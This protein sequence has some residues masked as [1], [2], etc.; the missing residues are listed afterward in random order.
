M[1]APYISCVGILLI[2]G[3]AA[4]HHARTLAV[5][6]DQDLVAY[7][8]AVD[9]KVIAEN[10]FYRDQLGTIR[11]YLGGNS[12]IAIGTNASPTNFANLTDEGR[13]Q[14][15]LPYGRIITR[16]EHDARI[17]AEKVISAEKDPPVMATIMA[18]VEGG[19]NEEQ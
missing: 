18:Y 2:C 4:D 12:P 19:L 9:A 5:H 13:I 16:A 14:K 6:V 11:K 7:E 8:N 17:E 10:K 15:T 1:K 3:C